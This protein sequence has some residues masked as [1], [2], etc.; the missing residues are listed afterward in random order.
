MVNPWK[1]LRWEALYRNY[2][3]F[4]RRYARL[5]YRRF[6]KANAVKVVEEEWDHLVLLDAC[7]YDMYADRLKMDVPWKVSGGSE[8][9]EWSE[10][11]FGGKC[12]D[13]VYVAGNP[14]LATAHLKRTFGKVPFHRVID[15]WDFGWSADL[16][17]VPPEEVTLA[18]IEAL[19]RYPDKRLI[20]HYNQPH[21]PF[22]ADAELVRIDAGTFHSVDDALEEVDKKGIWKVAKEGSVPMDKVWSGYRRNLDLVMREVD[23]LLEHMTGKVVLTAD[24]GNHAG[25]LMVFGHPHNLRTPCLVRVPWHT[26]KDVPRK[27]PEG[28][29][30]DDGKKLESE[31]ISDTVR[32]LKS[33]GL[34]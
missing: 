5:R 10:W 33:D 19:N 11:N 6:S 24:H 9:Q 27:A 15:V 13:I 30:K 25:E 7:R 26:I 23:R 14:H 3:R 32:R 12:K 28:K 22:I 20:V 4:L 29:G 17:T 34:I 16:K 21:H 2:L 31:H 18:A 8:T 1:R